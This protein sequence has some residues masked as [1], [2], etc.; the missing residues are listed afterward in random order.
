MIH[1]FCPFCWVEVSRDER[2]CLRCNRNLK[3][4]DEKSYVEK[5]IHSL[6]HFDRSTVYRVCYILGK[7][8]ETVAVKPLIDLLNTTND[9]FLMEE[10]VE[11]LGKI[12]DERAV[13]Y[14]INMLNNSSFLVRGKAAT[15]LGYFDS[16]EEVTQ[17]LKRAT[18]DISNYVRE[19]ARTS[20][21]KL[22]EGGC[23]A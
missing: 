13:P 21:Y 19:S 5:L 23:R 3:D 9:H 22:R 15:V 12:G 16:K 6:N 14:L 7:R 17:A 8:R 18:S 20:L 1:H 4:W 2:T 10:I 11:A